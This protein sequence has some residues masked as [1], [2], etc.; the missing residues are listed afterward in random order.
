MKNEF[1]PKAIALGIVFCVAAGLAGIASQALLWPPAQSSLTSS[2][3]VLSAP[4]SVWR[5]GKGNTIGLLEVDLLTLRLEDICE[6]WDCKLPRD[7]AALRRGDQIVVL[8]DG[9][10]VWQIESS[11][12]LIYS[13]DEAVRAQAVSRKRLNAICGAIAAAGALLIVWG[14]RAPPHR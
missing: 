3:H 14:R 12:G 4:P 10:A 9:L 1:R 8:R 5:P 7:V 11:A 13:Y 6:W 2:R